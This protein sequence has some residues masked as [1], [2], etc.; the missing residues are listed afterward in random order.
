MAGRR[1]RIIDPPIRELKRL[2]TRLTGGE[3]V[4]L[5]VLDSSLPLDWEIYIQPHLNGLR[6]DFVVMNP[7]V[8]IAVIEVKDTGLDPER[9]RY[10]LDAGFQ[11]KVG[12][13]GRWVRRT[14]R[15]PVAQ[16]AEYEWE[17]LNLYLPSLTGGTVS[18]AVLTSILVFAGPDGDGSVSASD[19][20]SVFGGYIGTMTQGRR[21]HELIVGL[22][23]FRAMGWPDTERKRSKLMSK[24]VADDLRN[25]LVEPRFSAE[26]R[27]RL[28]FDAQQREIVERATPGD[29]G[30]DRI[31]LRRVRGTAGSGKSCVVAGRAVTLAARGKR[32]LVL[33]YNHTLVGYLRDMSVRVLPDEGRGWDEPAAFMNFFTWCRRVVYA[34]DSKFWGRHWHDHSDPSDPSDHSDP[35]DPSDRFD[36]M[37]T[38]VGRLLE[39][40]PLEPWEQFDAVLVDEGQ[41]FSLDAWNLIRRHAIRPG[42]EGMLV[43]DVTQDLYENG[44]RWTDE[45]TMAGAGFS[46]RWATLLHSYRLPEE[47]RDHLARFV[48]DYVKVDGRLSP[49]APPGS[50]MQLDICDMR[51][52]QVA[53]ATPQPSLVMTE[54]DRIITASQ[55]GKDEK[56][57]D[58][59]WADLVVIVESKATGHAVVTALTARN[60][61]VTH[62]FDGRR[63]KVGFRKGAPNAKVT[64]IHSFKGFEGRSVLVVLDN[65]SPELAY[66][67]MTRVRRGIG[68]AFLTVVCSADSFEDYGRTWPDFERV[69]SASLAASEGAPVAGVT[70]SNA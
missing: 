27:D 69:A 37:P 31:A 51:W 26:Q 60:I 4:V 23:D 47:L 7:N 70:D 66:T 15:D 24:E 59:A 49:L 12:S 13:P 33:T 53:G 19:I 11:V 32:V 9:Y 29:A 34:R 67:G 6:P 22:E 44:R 36:T 10:D 17:I 43:A 14:G 68:R 55:T 20:D 2:R 62:T 41:D 45:Q 40:Q 65:H 39:E 46:G 18:T 16:L 28:T 8:G 48:E 63:S 50:T 56:D 5:D 1:Q 30:E 54:I 21:D 3:E 64:T 42:G 52:V 57:R 58:L 25:W 61:T 38:V 35:S